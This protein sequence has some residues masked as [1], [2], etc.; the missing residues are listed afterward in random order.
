MQMNKLIKADKWK[1]V[2]SLNFDRDCMEVVKSEYHCL[3]SAGPGAGKTELLAQRASYLLQT[4]KSKHPQ[5]ILALSYKVDSAKNLEDRV[6]ERCGEE[7]SKRFISRTYDAFAKSILDQFSNLLPEFYRVSPDYEIGGLIDVENAYKAVRLPSDFKLNK[8]YKNTYL[9]E[10]K[11]PIV[12]SPYGE[13]AKI[14]WPILLRGN[15]MLK[16][17]LTFKMISR[18]AEYIIRKNSLVKDSLNFTYS[19]VFLDE[20]QDT[21][22][23]HYDLIVSCFHNSDSVI[24][25]VGDKKQRVMIWAGALPTVFEN[26]VAEFGATEKTLLVNHRSAPKLIQLQK[27]IAEKMLG[28]EVNIVSN[29]RWGRDDG[30]SETWLFKNTNEEADFICKKIK[31]LIE[32]EKIKPKDVCILVRKLP[33]KYTQAVMS[34][35]KEQNIE[36]RIEEAYQTLLKEELVSICLSIIKLTQNQVSPDEWIFIMDILKKLKGYSSRT[37]IDRLYKVEELLSR[38]LVE[39]KSILDNIQNEAQFKL[40]IESII[41]YINLDLLK[42]LFPHYNNGYV[43][44]LLNRLVSL[45]WKEYSTCGNWDLAIQ[46]FKGEHS[47]AIMTIHKSKGLEYDTVILLGVEDNSFHGITDNEDEELCT[48]FVGVSRAIRRLYFTYSEYRDGQ[49]KKENVELFYKLLEESNIV[50]TFK[51]VDEYEKAKAEYF[52]ET[53]IQLVPRK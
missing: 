24:T 12:D 5:K 35:L 29:D 17:R 53:D 52:G 27:P 22:V 14:I 15:E 42:G 49:N 31:C 18:L 20:F 36:A 19:H 8:F 23:H 33:D 13:I 34:K 38:Y 4:N 21:P 16:A 25:A 40:A 10:N 41:E 51:F 44:G 28:T 45:L 48:F 50:V 39:L 2:D 11:L 6:K 47:I 43:S 9:T 26:F 32:E 30:E 3:V 1:P 7:L 46:K 37:P